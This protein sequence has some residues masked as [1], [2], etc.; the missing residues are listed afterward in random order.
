MTERTLRTTVLILALLCT[1]TSVHGQ[2]IAEQ[3]VSN[4]E[5]NL[6]ATLSSADYFGSSVTTLGDVDGDG[7]ADLAVG[8]EGDDAFVPD[9]GAVYLL[10]MNA[11]GSVREHRKLTG[12]DLPSGAVAGGGNLGS[13]VARIDDLNADGVRDMIVGAKGDDDTSSGLGESSGAAWILFLDTAGNVIAEQKISETS[14]GF[15]GSLDP[16]DLFGRAVAILGDIG[17]N[18]SMEVAV[19]APGDDDG[20]TD[21]GAIWILSLD[22]NGSVSTLKKISDGN[23]LP[24]NALA[25]YDG[26]G[27]SISRL[28]KPND[29]ILIAVG[30]PFDDTGGPNRGAAWVLELD[31]LFNVVE[32]Q[33]HASSAGGL[34]APLADGSLFGRSVAGP[35]DL[36]GD[37]QADAMVGAPAASTTDDHG[38]FWFENLEPGTYSVIDFS[39]VGS[40]SGGFSGRLQSGDRFGQSLAAIG[41]HDGDGRVDYAVGVPYSDDGAANSGSIYVL[42]D[43]QA[44]PVAIEPKLPADEVFAEPYPNPFRD[45]TTMSLRLSADRHVRIEI[46]DLLGRLVHTLHDGVLKAGES[47]SIR[48]DASGWASGIYVYRVVN[49]DQVVAR[50]M[51]IAR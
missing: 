48:L 40:S 24:A 26:F 1:T 45:E 30:A 50:K 37:D 14:G 25:D 6:G 5:G 47:H 3:E 32:M 28:T 15:I 10:F 49:G 21:R 19:G 11:D 46:Y 23:G 17:S 27:T 43:N 9:G 7:V 12:N 29:G 41:D 2:L 31:P 20:G 4:S 42:F 22:S 13:A 8:A 34:A 36:D 18:G 16:G 39:R 51:V 38:E 44:E 33:K 35:G